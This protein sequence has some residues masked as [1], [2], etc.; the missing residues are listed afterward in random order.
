MTKLYVVD[1]APLLSDW[2]SR[3]PDAPLV[4]LQDILDEV[5]NGPSK[6]RVEALISSGRLRVEAVRSESVNRVR[7]K[8]S[9]VGDGTKLSSTDVEVVALALS[10]KELGHDV[11]LVSSDLA[12]LNTA[13]S[14]GIGTLDTENRFKDRIVWAFRCP[15]C[16]FSAKV[17]PEG[18]DCPVC[19]TQMRRKAVRRLRAV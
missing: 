19:G 8:A 1:T 10:M 3:V 15:A 12:V 5:L 18:L 11:V 4:T 9:D 14:L 17:A 2:S 6:R 16:G 13:A 7:T